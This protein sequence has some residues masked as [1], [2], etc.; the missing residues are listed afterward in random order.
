M[1]NAQDSEFLCQVAAGWL[2]E[3][4]GGGGWV[5]WGWVS[6]GQFTA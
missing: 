4:G 2:G 1:G 3:C 6:G 5:G